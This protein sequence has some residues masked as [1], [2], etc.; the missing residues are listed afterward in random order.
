MD[1]N[2]GT[3]IEFEGGVLHQQMAE[4]LE[5]FLFPPG[6]EHHRDGYSVSQEYQREFH[7][8]FSVSLGKMVD[9]LA[10]QYAI[11]KINDLV[12]PEEMLCDLLMQ[13]IR[14][15]EAD[16][17]GNIMREALRGLEPEEE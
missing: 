7:R 11:G 10:Q 17:Q 8:R 9:V 15:K 4:L 13:E 1:L 2:L 16:A 5:A 6:A 14:R 12:Y 3:Q